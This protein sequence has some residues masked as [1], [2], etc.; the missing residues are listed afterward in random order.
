MSGNATK[1][2]GTSAHKMERLQITGERQAPR[3]WVPHSSLRSHSWCDGL[4][5]LSIRNLLLSPGQLK[6]ESTVWVPS[7]GWLSNIP[8]L[9]LSGETPL[10]HCPN[11]KATAGTVTTI[12]LWA[13]FSSRILHSALRA[14]SHSSR[15]LAPS[16]LRTYL[17]SELKE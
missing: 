3:V 13:R 4:P 12:Y 17:V 14:G 5:S 8:E 10:S 7:L 9:E 16:R 2:R 1:A 15:L 6:Y 11:C